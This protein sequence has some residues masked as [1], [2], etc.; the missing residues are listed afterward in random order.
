MDI[1]DTE[2]NM[3]GSLEAEKKTQHAPK[4]SIK[5]LQCAWGL[6]ILKTRAAYLSAFKMNWLP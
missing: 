3:Q 2:A 6:S 5:S 1:M 4:G